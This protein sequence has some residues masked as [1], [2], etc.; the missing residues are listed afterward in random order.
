LVVAVAA[1]VLS[2]IGA[3]GDWWDGKRWDQE[4]SGDLHA[5]SVTLAAT[6]GKAQAEALGFDADEYDPDQTVAFLKTVA[7]RYAV[8][9]NQ[10]T[11]SQL[12]DAVADPDKD[13]ASVFDT[14]K[15]SR[16]AGGG[17]MVATFMTG[18]AVHE[19]A[20]QIT[21]RNNVEPTKTWITG[22]NPRAEHAALDGE[23]VG[24]DET[25]SD[26]SRW[27]GDGPDSAGCNCEMDVNV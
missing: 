17:A 13:P 11:K 21:F 15:D 23:T 22:S 10:T 2:A 20:A 19:A 6:V 27:P 16:A 8:N 26:G 14:A 18:F 12:D 24:L 4:L 1:A 3:G 5:A 9:I 25:F 7:D